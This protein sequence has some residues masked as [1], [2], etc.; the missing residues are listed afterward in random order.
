MARGFW[1]DSQLHDDC[2]KNFT[3]DTIPT[4]SDLEK[5]T[6]YTPQDNTL[7]LHEGFPAATITAHLETTFEEKRRTLRKSKLEPKKQ[8]AYFEIDFSYPQ[9][10]GDKNFIFNAGEVRVALSRYLRE[11]SPKHPKQY[12]LTS[13][14]ISDHHPD[15]LRITFVN[16][17][18][19]LFEQ[20]EELLDTLKGI[21]K[22]Q[23]AGH[24]VLKIKEH[25]AESEEIR[26]AFKSGEATVEWTSEVE[27]ERRKKRDEGGPEKGGNGNGNGDD[28]DGGNGHNRPRRPKRGGGRGGRGGGHGN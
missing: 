18:R 5:H 27:K 8:Q 17:K 9:R 13:K 14:S 7:T 15:K 10:V 3:A 28:G 11:H 23:L 1:F 16:R 24:D 25:M 4:G 19:P 12:V 2:P 21:E 6:Q 22:E 20:F 26:E